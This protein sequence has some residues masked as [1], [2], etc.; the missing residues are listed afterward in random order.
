MLSAIHWVRRIQTFDKCFRRQACFTTERCDNTIPAAYA[1]HAGRY[2]KSMQ[3]YPTA[4]TTAQDV[5]EAV[6]TA[7]TDERDQLRYPA[8]ADSHML[9]KLRHSLSEHEFI[10]RIRTMTGSD[11]SASTET[12]I[13]CFGG[14]F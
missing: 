1:E 4:Y 3:T 14:A 8:G 10:A 13:K 6:F 2:M 9:A 5:A 11:L 7:A 12:A